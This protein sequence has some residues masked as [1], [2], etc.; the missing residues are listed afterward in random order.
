MIAE[1]IISDSKQPGNYELLNLVGKGRLAEV[2]LARQ[3]H[4]NFAVALKIITD[5]RGNKLLRQF[6]QEVDVL[7]RLEHPN[8]LTPVDYGNTGDYLYLA[9]PLATGGSLKTRLTDSQFSQT[10][11]LQL[12]DRILVGLDFA[13]SNGIIHGDLKPAN[14]LFLTHDL[15]R[16]VISDFGL[17]NTLNLNEDISLT[18]TGSIT[19]SPEYMAP[20]QFTGHTG[21]ASDQYAAAVILFELL[22]GQNLY[23]GNTAWELGMRHTNDPLPLP[24]RRIPA[25]LELFF[26]TALN[27]SPDRRFKNTKE[28]RAAFYKAISQPSPLH[29]EN[30]VELPSS[31]NFNTV[32]KTTYKQ[33]GIRPS[34]ELTLTP[35]CRVVPEVFPATGRARK[36]KRKRERMLSFYFFLMVLLMALICLLLP[37]IFFLLSNF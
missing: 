29:S 12:F 22:T 7:A 6:E 21:Q 36:D 23:Q 9:M 31:T 17:S 28:M 16:P 18:L 19:G 13:H 20:E 30:P 34:A 4:L 11:A 1:K 25:C 10:E 33:T 14:I 26:A 2:W 5:R 37:Q 8:I 35:G 15:T 3:V 32:N 27:K 24:H